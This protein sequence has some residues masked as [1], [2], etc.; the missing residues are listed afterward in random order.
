MNY[1]LYQQDRLPIRIQSKDLACGAFSLISLA[2]G[3]ERDNVVY[4]KETN[5]NIISLCAAGKTYQTKCA[6]GQIF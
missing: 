4:L 5:G 6:T 1:M 2:C 3:A